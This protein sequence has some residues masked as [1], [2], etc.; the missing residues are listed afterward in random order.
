[1]LLSKEIAAIGVDLRNESKSRPYVRA[2]MPEVV[3]DDTFW[4]MLLE[5]FEIVLHRRGYVV[6]SRRVLEHPV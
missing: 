5:M 6:V 1:M 2:L 3:D 4:G